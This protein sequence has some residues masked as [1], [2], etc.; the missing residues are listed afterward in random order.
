MVLSFF[1]VDERCIV[2]FLE[3]SRR[4][5]PRLMVI[6]YNIYFVSENKMYVLVTADHIQVQILLIELSA[7]WRIININLI[8]I[9]KWLMNN[10]I[11]NCYDIFVLHINLL[12]RV[13]VGDNER[14]CFGRADVT[15][16]QRPDQGLRRVSSDCPIFP[17]HVMFYVIFTVTFCQPPTDNHHFLLIIYYYFH[18]TSTHWVTTV[19]CFVFLVYTGCHIFLF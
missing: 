11:N 17:S 19:F 2:C 4:K 6:I 12:L 14:R 8:R 7:P 15:S 16:D 9:L 18:H 10:I 3:A 1:T 5:T 13:P